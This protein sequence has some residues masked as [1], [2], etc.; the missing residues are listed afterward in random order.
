[1]KQIAILSRLTSNRRGVVAV[2]GAVGMM[3][4]TGA[5]FLAT[6]LTRLHIAR[7]RLQAAADAAM[8][9]GARELDADV[10]RARATAR[11]V[12]DANLPN[13]FLGLTVTDFDLK[14]ESQ[15]SAQGFNDTVRL[16]VEADLPLFLA[17]LGSKLNAD[18]PSLASLAIQSGAVKKTMGAE[19]ALVLDNT[20]SMN[21]KKIKDL[22]KAAQTLVDTVFQGQETLPNLLVGIVNYSATVNIGQ[23]HAGWLNPAATPGFVASEWKGCVM[24]RGGALDE[25][26]API[27]PADPATQVAPFRWPSSNWESGAMQHPPTIDTAACKK[28]SGGY[29]NVWPDAAGN[30]DERQS[31]RNA[32]YGPNLSCPD[33]ITPLV[34]S[35][36][37]LTTEIK[38]IDAWH[39]GGTFSNIG[40]SWGWR[41]LSPDWQ[42]QWRKPDGTP[43]IGLP[44][45]YDRAFNHKII[46]LMTDGDNNHYVHDFTAY[47]EDGANIPSGGIDASMTRLCT[48]IKDAGII[49]FTV[50]FGSTSSGI[51]TLFRGC[52]SNP[53]TEK[54][55][56]GPFY[57]DAPSGSDL[58][59]AFRSIGG[60]IQDL[61]L[62]Q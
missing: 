62:I 50:T 17:N 33:A 37:Q 40:L 45:P 54:R 18:L 56:G 20:G 2:L 12:F 5:T 4:V 10:A 52:A 6:D 22:R 30:F 1:M 42:D 53:A 11:A 24:A 39:R 46:V 26:D 59:A 58:Q 41:M 13:D 25:S 35:H 32:G 36:S 7:A 23:Q 21:G 48:S 43:I 61:R 60:Q 9:A 15:S 19:I 31:A 38:E 14:L 49:I 8:L 28:M 34:S 51:E 55:L 57:F 29:C 27:D 47:G 44:Y 3:V 16:T